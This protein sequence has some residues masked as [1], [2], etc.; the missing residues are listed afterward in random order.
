MSLIE[1]TL[2]NF[3]VAST[4]IAAI[5]GLHCRRRLLVELTADHPDE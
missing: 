2:I 4:T 3:R 5:V 1:T